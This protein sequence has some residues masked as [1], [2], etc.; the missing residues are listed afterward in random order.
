MK[1]QYENLL[2]NDNQDHPWMKENGYYPNQPEIQ[3]VGRET[4]SVEE[5]A[6]ALSKP[7]SV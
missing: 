2:Y 7:F 3:E 1:C 4:I 6:E 5:I